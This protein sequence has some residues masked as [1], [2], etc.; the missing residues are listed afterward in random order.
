[1]LVFERTSGKFLRV[2]K[3]RVFKGS[4]Y[5]DIECSVNGKEEVTL[6]IGAYKGTDYAVNSAVDFIVEKFASA[7]KHVLPLV[8][9]DIMLEKEF[10]EVDISVA[11]AKYIPF[12]ENEVI[13]SGEKQTVLGYRTHSYEGY[14]DIWLLSSVDIDSFT[15]EEGSKSLD[16]RI[17]DFTGSYLFYVVKVKKK[18]VPA[19]PK[20]AAEKLKTSLKSVIDRKEKEEGVRL[21]GKTEY[22]TIV[23]EAL[24]ADYYVSI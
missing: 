14:T 17:K 9:L 23:L 6:R 21:L 11:K 8:D 10:K 22:N 13:L 12:I 5:F 7:D 1:M 15:V 16:I 19:F 2:D 20:D 4:D 24:G 18:N 3:M